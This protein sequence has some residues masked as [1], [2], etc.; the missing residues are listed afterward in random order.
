V[1]VGIED[2]EE[3]CGLGVAT[4]QRKTRVGKT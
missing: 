3:R 2:A 1:E 4:K